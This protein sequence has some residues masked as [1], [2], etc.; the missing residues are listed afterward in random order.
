MDDRVSQLCPLPREAV[1]AKNKSTLYSVHPGI[2][3]VQKWI[4]ELPERTGKSLDQWMNLINKE[5][6]KTE[7]A[8]RD[9]LKSEHKFGTNNASW[10]AQRSVGKATEDDDPDLYLQAAEKYVKAMFAAKPDLV[11]IY[12]KVLE[13]GLALGKDVKACPCQTIVPLYR[14]NVF[15]QLKPTTKTRLDLG[16]CLRGVPFTD[17]LVDTGGTAKKDRITHRIGLTSVKEIDGEVKRRF[18]QAYEMDS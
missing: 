14:K 1:M 15:A 16:F 13:L 5:G 4:A 11:P 9:W 12:E 2:A 17:R 18:K 7:E 3:M 8:R 6:P 10:L